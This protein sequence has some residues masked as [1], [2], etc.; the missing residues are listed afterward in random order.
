MK[1]LYIAGV[2]QFGGSSRSLYEV[3]GPLT[4]D[5]TVQPVFV[6]IHGTAKDYFAK[7]TDEIELI[8]GMTKFNNTMVSHYR[9][10]RW[11]ILLR[12][13]A[14]LPG[15]IM[16]LRRAARRWPDIDMIHINDTDLLL[17]GI[18]AK[19]IF[20]RPLIV[21]QRCVLYSNPRSRRVRLM[22]WL[23]RRH[24]DAIVAI[25]ETCRASLPA[26]MS[27]DIVH[28]SFAPNYPEGWDSDPG[29]SKPDR[30]LV[31]G[32]VG[33][34]LRSKGIIELVRAIGLARQR[35][36]DV[37]LMV[38][39]GRIRNLNGLKRAMLK[40]AR[41]EQDVLPEVEHIVAEM[42]IEDAVTF[43]G[44]TGEI[45][46]LYSQVDVVAFPSHLDAPGRP[47]FE[48]AF[49]KVPSIVCVSDP[50]PDTVR[51]GE[52]ALVVAEKDP[53]ALAEAII[54]CDRDRAELRRMGEA[55]YDLAWQ[56][57]DPAKNADLLA[58]IYARTLGTAAQH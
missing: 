48:A 29:P 23:L 6:A 8:R 9:G 13:L 26:D 7:L 20:G 53:D 41:L 21:H 58:K 39:G 2:A 51:P 45:S 32:F 46:K 47:V 36:V 44:H 55:A 16:V 11:F 30:P 52:T 27:V 10:V 33:N 54:A 31:I 37:R 3:L 4:A 50:K 18:I 34:V 14:Y 22:H 56:N 49:F 40:A 38:V 15:T 1:T 19:R 57:F 17:S 25:D 43:A 12:E 24:A 5:D 28:N 42:Q 35:G